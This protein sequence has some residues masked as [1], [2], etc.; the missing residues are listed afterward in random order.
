MNA[1]E[2]SYLLYHAIF[3]VWVENE[4]RHTHI[5]PKVGSYPQALQGDSPS[6]RTTSLHLGGT[7]PPLIILTLRTHL[8]P[9]PNVNIL[10]ILAWFQKVIFPSI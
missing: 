2:S 4:H 10:N 9:A 6:P 3:H 5:Y 1:W 8:Y 7:P